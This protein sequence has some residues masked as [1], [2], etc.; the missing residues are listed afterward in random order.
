MRVLCDFQQG[1]ILPVDCSCSTCNRSILSPITLT[2]NSQPSLLL[3]ILLP[4]FLTLS[5]SLSVYCLSVYLSLWQ[6][7]SFFFSLSIVH[8][9]FFR[10]DNLCLSFSHC[11]LFICLC[12]TLY[13]YLCTSIS[14]IPYYLSV[15]FL[16]FYSIATSLNLCQQYQLLS[17]CQWWT[18]DDNDNIIFQKH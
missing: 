2:G 17:T 11:L 5:L 10:S 3:F 14:Q 7:M 6:S 4:H 9:F 1:H 15:C 16:L 18:L 8:L 13:H 12:P